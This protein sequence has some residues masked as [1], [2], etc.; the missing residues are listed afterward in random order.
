M[1][2]PEMILIPFRIMQEWRLIDQIGGSLIES[3]WIKGGEEAEIGD[4]GLVIGRIAIA[5]G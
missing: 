4:Y 2:T 5:V 3:D 1:Q